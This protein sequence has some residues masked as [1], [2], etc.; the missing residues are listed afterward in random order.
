[1]RFQTTDRVPCDDA[2][3]VLAVL[4]DRLHTLGAREVVRDGRRITLFGLG[5]SPRAINP[6]DKTMIEVNAA[7]GVTTIDADVSF[8]ASSFLGEAPQDQIVMS[9]LERVFDEIKAE[10]GLNGR[11][12]GEGIVPLRKIVPIKSVPVES[13]VA[14][15]NHPEEFVLPETTVEILAETETVAAPHDVPSAV[16]EETPIAETAPEPI[17]EIVRAEDGPAG[18]WDNER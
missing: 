16:V 13:F 4:E 8:Q 5:P 18:H 17:A 10:L 14:A 2:E 15:A 7:D 9:K 1:M 3:L 11:R 12:V 6:R